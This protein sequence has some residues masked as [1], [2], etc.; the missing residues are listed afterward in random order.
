ME[1]KQKKGRQL[2]ELQYLQK[3][4]QLKRQRQQTQL[5]LFVS[6]TCLIVISVVFGWFQAGMDYLIEL[7]VKMFK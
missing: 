7:I 6:S 4:N 2:A 5:I 1:Q 3:M